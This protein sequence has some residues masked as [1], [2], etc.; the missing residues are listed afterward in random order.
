MLKIDPNS[1][2]LLALGSRTL[3]PASLFERHSVTDLIA[4]S[5]EVFFADLG[6]ALF[7]L[8]RDAPLGGKTARRADLLLIDPEGRLYVGRLQHGK[9]SIDLV[10][11]LE[12]AG[13]V[14]S[15]GPRQVLS[16]LDD[17]RRELLRTFLQAPIERINAEQGLLLLAEE[18]DLDTLSAAGWL[19]ARYGVRI[20]CYQLRLA[21]DS[22]TQIDYLD[23][24]DLSDQVDE[25]YRSR[26]GGQPDGAPW[27]ATIVPDISDSPAP[28]HRGAG[29]TRARGDGPAS[30]AGRGDS[31]FRACA[32]RRTGAGARRSRPGR[33]GG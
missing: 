23:C 27:P 9:A 26:K 2:T 25:V 30:P 16:L 7:L 24:Q 1:N 32:A 6:R 17:R 20:D 33:R 12:D 15:W 19:K 31:N 14:A 18:F 10:E 28:E 22:T 5:P 3:E 21:S 8:A 11:A 29:G 13:R 4:N